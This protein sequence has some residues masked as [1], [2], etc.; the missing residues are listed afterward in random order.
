MLVLAAPG[1]A[2]PRLMPAQLLFECAFRLS[3]GTLFHCLLFLQSGD[4]FLRLVDGAVR[5]PRTRGD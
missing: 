4:F 1:L 5:H 3:W 2:H